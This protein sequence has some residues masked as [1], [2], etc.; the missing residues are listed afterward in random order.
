MCIRDSTQTAVKTF[1]H[2]MVVINS[3]G[4][5]KWSNDNFLDMI[6]RESH[7][8][9][10]IQ[11][12]FNNLSINRYLESQVNVVD[13]FEFN[14]RTYLING[15]A[16]HSD[17]ISDTLAGLYFVDITD[18][19]ELKQDFDDKQCVQCLVVIDNYDEVLKETP[20]S[21]HGALLGEI[22]RCVNAWVSNANGVSRRYEREKFLVFFLSLIHI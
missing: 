6:G 15:R 12:L 16:V 17:L 5:I 13:E 2:P 18:F 9:E 11:D 4:E 7:Y 22:E 19:M 8:G 10:Y 3:E 1:V 14:G 20:N 21:N